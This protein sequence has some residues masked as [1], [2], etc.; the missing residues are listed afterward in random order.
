MIISNSKT[1]SL[2]MIFLTKICLAVSKIIL[3]QYLMFVLNTLLVVLWDAFSF[4]ILTRLNMESNHLP[5]N[6]LTTGISSLLHSIANLLIS[7]DQIWRK[8]FQIISLIHINQAFCYN[9]SFFSH[10]VN[11]YTIYILFSC[12]FVCLDL[13][14]LPLIFNK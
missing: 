13:P 8:R 10:F 2:F 4:P 5:A 9:F 6:V 1:V 14:S 3:K 12:I 11:I 7:L